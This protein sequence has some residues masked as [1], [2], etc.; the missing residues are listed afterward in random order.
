MQGKI[1]T[2]L[3]LLLLLLLLFHYYVVVSRTFDVNNTNR[4]LEY[5]LPNAAARIVVGSGIC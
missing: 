5:G 1:A 3:L 4:S 2:L